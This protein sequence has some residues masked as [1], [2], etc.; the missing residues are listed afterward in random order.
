[1]NGVSGGGFLLDGPCG[2]APCYAKAV[3]VR[4]ALKQMG[5]GSGINKVNHYHPFYAPGAPP[6]SFVEGEMFTTI[7]PLAPSVAESRA[8][9]LLKALLTTP[10]HS[11][12]KKG[13]K[14]C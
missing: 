5:M 14:A 7:I 10:C 9:S 12:Y 8:E 13:L 2:M 1:M 11:L 4:L 6:P 3:I